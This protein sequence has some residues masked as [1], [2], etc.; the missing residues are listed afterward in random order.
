MASNTATESNESE[1]APAGTASTTTTASATTGDNTST[2]A[3]ATTT[4][5]ICN[6]SKMTPTG[7]TNIASAT[8]L[9]KKE[10]L[11]AEGLLTLLI[12]NVRHGGAGSN[13][14]SSEVILRLSSLITAV[15]C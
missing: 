5:T 7:S 6:T 12:N 3:T 8:T 15:P 14:S 10:Q 1:N 4:A 11:R 2:N 9:V 13:R